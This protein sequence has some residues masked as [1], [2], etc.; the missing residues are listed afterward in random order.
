MKHY[1][2]VFSEQLDCVNSLCVLQSYADRWY[3]CAFLG[4]TF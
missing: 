3:F 2:L 4:M 1:E